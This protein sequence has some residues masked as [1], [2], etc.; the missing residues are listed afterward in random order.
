[1]CSVID[2]QRNDIEFMYCIDT[3]AFHYHISFDI[4][5]DLTLRY[6]NRQL[7]IDNLYKDLHSGKISLSEFVRKL[8]RI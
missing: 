8:E 3:Y 7:L 4:Y 5:P 2:Q 6:H 1:M